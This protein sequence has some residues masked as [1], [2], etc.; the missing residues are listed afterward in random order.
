MKEAVINRKIDLYRDPVLYEAV[1][2]WKTNDIDFICDWVMASGSPVL[3]LAAG[4]GRLAKPLAGKGVDYSGLDASPVFV[5]WANKSLKR[6]SATASVVQADMRSFNIGRDF[7]SA[8]IGFNSIFHLMTDADI[9]QCFE[10]VY[11]HLVPGGKFL[12][13]CFNPNP[14][15]L[16]PD[17]QGQ[18]KVFEFAHPDG[19]NCIVKETN[20]YQ[21]LTQ[22]NR[23]NW[24]FYRN[25]NDLPDQYTFDLHMIYPGTM[26]RLLTNA[27]FTV[28]NKWGG[29]DKHVFSK[30][31]PLQIYE[32]RK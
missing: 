8:L 9:Q 29:Y 10:S 2:R 1:H 27:G 17:N 4:T 12:I 25:G 24:F 23:I 32:C 22:I 5:D 21:D 6:I 18:K 14:D 31:S 28:T 30:D 7:H 16:Y 13:D 3:E 26:D 15:F 19:G 11:R 20:E